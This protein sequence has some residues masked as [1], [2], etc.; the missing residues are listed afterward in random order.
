MKVQSL[1]HVVL[2]VRDRDR[3]EAFYKDVLG[4]PLV[5]RMEKYK[6]SFFSLGNHHDFAIAEVGSE[7]A[8]ADAN[9]PGLAHVAFKVGDDLAALKRAK[10]DLDAAGVEIRAVDHGVSQS[11]YFN[12]PDGNGL[13]V[14][15]DGSDA[16]RE[17]PQLVAHSEP[18]E[19]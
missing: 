12:D 16:W 8:S 19:I 4:L 10:A 6:M 17:D 18:L 5:A 1:G 13:E 11:L 15:V 7:A 3:S 14:Y 2:K 9:M